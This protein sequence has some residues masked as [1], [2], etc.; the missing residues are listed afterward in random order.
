MEEDHE[1]GVEAEYP[2]TETSSEQPLKLLEVLIKAI[3]VLLKMLHRA[4]LGLSYIR[5]AR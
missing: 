2:E 3:L 4:L 1:V 5:H